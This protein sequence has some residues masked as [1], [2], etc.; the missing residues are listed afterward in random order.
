MLSPAVQQGV[1]P[2]IGQSHLN[3]DLSH[4]GHVHMNDHYLQNAAHP[5]AAIGNN[6]RRMK[7]QFAARCIT[8]EEARL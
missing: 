6:H 3:M 4:G 5:A 1:L 7:A 8:K 2:S